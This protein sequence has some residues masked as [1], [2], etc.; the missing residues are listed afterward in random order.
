[1][2]I[3]R[4]RS[5]DIPELNTA[6]LPDLIFT[7]LFFFML[8]THMRKVAVKVKYQVPQGT[9]LTKLVKKTA[10]TY[11]YIGKPMNETGQLA[12]DSLCIQMNDKLVDVAEIKSY[13]VKERATM[14]A[15]DK[16]QMSVS[17]RADKETPMGRII[18]IKQSLREANV[19]NVN[20]AA[21]KKKK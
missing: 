8:V 16:K 9:E 10:I 15:E 5:H 6:S 4:R 7:I 11:L 20:Y 2:S 1:M 12:S 14:S 21:T 17:I 19:L 3:Y 13:L 18:D